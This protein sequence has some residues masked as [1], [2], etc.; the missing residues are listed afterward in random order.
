MKPFLFDSEITDPLDVA[1]CVHMEY[2]VIAEPVH[3]LKS[4]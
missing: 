3:I 4:A 1:Y 2:V